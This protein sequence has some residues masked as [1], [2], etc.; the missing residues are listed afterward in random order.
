MTNKFRVEALDKS[1]RDV[2]RFHNPQYADQPFGGKVVVFGRDFRQILHVVPKGSRQD[3]V[4]AALNSSYLWHSCTVLKLTKNMRLQSASSSSGADEF[5]QRAILAPTNEIVVKVNDYVLSKMV[6]V[7]KEYLSSDSISKAKGYASEQ[8]EL[9]SAEFLNSIRCSGLPN[10]KVALKIGTPIMLM[11]NLDQSA[12][13]CN[14]TRLVVN[15]LGNHI[16]QATVITGTNIGHKVFIPRMS[17]TPSA[18]NTL[19]I[20][21]QCRQFPVMVCYAMT[22]NKSQG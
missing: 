4:H 17:L 14:G 9:Y 6:G 3:I 22:I 12:G 2:M 21:F 8:E 11:R 15:Q 19:P 18:S 5:Q 16:I 13:L 20:N 1:L 10:H 7:E